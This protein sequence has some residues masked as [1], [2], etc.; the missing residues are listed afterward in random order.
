MFL[1]IGKKKIGAKF[2]PFFVAE[3]ST[4]H[5]SNFKTACDL[6]DVAK[7]CGAD[8][9]K[10]QTYTADTMTLDSDSKNFIIKNKS[11]PFYKKTLYSLY[12]KGSMPWEWHKELKIKAEKNDLIFFSTPFDETSLNFLSNLKVP[13]YKIASFECTDLP[14]IALVAKK[15]KPMII[16]TGM[17]TINEISDAV[18]TA[19]K[20]GCSKIVLLKCTSNYPAKVEDS[21]L[22]SIPYLRKKFNCLVGLSDHT[23]GIGASI[24][25]VSYG[26][27]MIEKHL[28]L[29]KNFRSIDSKFSMDPKEF[30]LLI[31]ETTLAWKSSGKIFFGPSKNEKI[32]KKY[33]RSIF[34]I[35][36]IKKNEKFSKYNIRV[37]RPNIGMQPKFFTKIL[38][39]KAKKEIKIGTPIKQNYF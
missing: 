34:A 7:N 9:V 28:K 36:N 13:C 11:S 26:A 24:A 25:S 4:N 1:K 30:K 29:N 20:N 15:R 32:S 16:S 14:L 22:L 33:R 10:F 31:D 39:K 18:Y 6:I 5:K 3:I 17:A 12:K 23:L 8:A 38:G 2:K 37:L 21:N 19:K 27:V 35:N